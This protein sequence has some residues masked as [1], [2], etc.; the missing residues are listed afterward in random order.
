MTL[1]NFFDM[2]KNIFFTIGLLILSIGL[3]AQSAESVIKSAVEKLK[4]YDNI[5][6]AF[7]YN[8]INTEAGIYETMEGSGFLQGDAYKLKIMG[9]DIVC[10]GTTRWIYNADAEEVMISNVDKTDEGGSPFKIINNYNENI[11]AKFVEESGNIRKIEVKTLFGNDDTEKVIIT[12]D[13][14]SLEIKDLHIFDKEKTEFVYE[15]KKFVT[16]QNL[17]ADFF[18]FKAPDYPDAEIIDMR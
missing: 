7:E 3:M 15:M 1:F 4:S 10:D 18:T 2:R 6:I 12:L 14:K 11:S 16:N 13:I 8:M 5:E 9:Q 17:P